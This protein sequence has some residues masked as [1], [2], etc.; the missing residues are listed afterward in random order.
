MTATELKIRFT[1]DAAGNA[2]VPMDY[3]G[4]LVVKDQIPVPRLI[5]GDTGIEAFGGSGTAVEL[6]SD[7]FI[8]SF[9]S[10][11]GLFWAKLSAAS[12]MAIAPLVVLGWMTQR[13]LVRGLTFGAVT[14]RSPARAKL[15]APTTR[16]S[17]R[18]RRERGA[19]LTENL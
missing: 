9:S 6:P 1:A 17:P 4:V 15:A 16:G 13:Q 11:E 3:R 19:H 18:R 10:P 12:T 8:A 7:A 14:Y 2:L 5:L